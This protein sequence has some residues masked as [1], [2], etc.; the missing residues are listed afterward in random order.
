MTSILKAS[1]W[2]YTLS[3]LHETFSDLDPT[4]GPKSV[5][6]SWRLLNVHSD[7]FSK[8]VIFKNAR[9]FPPPFNIIMLLNHELLCGCCYLIIVPFW[10][11]MCHKNFDS[12][13]LLCVNGWYVVLLHHHYCVIL[14]WERPCRNFVN[15][16]LLL[17]PVLSLDRSLINI[18]LLSNN[19]KKPVTIWHT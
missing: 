5:K 6:V 2:T 1:L 8:E 13:K 3:N 17:L 7:V 15:I 14:G 19:D 10:A 16:E 12:T 9:F 11:M 18:Y 4:L